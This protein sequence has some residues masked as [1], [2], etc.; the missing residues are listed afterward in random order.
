MRFGRKE[1]LLFTSDFRH[2]FSPKRIPLFVLF[3]IG[4]IG[5]AVQR[6]D[7]SP[8]ILVIVTSLSVVESQFNNLLYRSPEELEA[9]SM[10]PLDWRGL[11]AARNI[12]TI[13]ALLTTIL[14]MSTALLYFS[15]RPPE[16]GEA[17]E[18]SLYL[19]TILFPLLIIGNLRSV[20]EPHR[21]VAA[22]RDQIVQGFGMALL[23]LAVSIPYVLFHTLVRSTIPSMIYATLSAFAWWRY[24]IPST[25]F[26]ARNLL[27][28]S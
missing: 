26:R 25:A 21:A 19:G 7:L 20:Q 28:K 27:T 11:I 22:I 15:P 8:L 23:A 2:C 18:M 16:F 10:F 3:A 12:A 1:W 9:L 24:S 4:G 6:G 17:G 5:V 13:A 14:M